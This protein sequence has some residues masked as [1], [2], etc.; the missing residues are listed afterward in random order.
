VAFR[1]FPR[2]VIDRLNKQINAVLGQPDVKARMEAAEA[3]VTP[4]AVSEFR[5]F[6]QRESAKYLHVIEETGVSLQ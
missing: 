6:V 3:V 4:L 1:P 2:T 5:D